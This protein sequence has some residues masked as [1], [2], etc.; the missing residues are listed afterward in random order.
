MAAFP[1]IQAVWQHV[2][3]MLGLLTTGT[4]ELAQTEYRGCPKENRMTDDRDQRIDALR[5]LAREGAQQKTLPSLDIAAQKPPRRRSPQGAADCRDLRARGGRGGGRADRA[6]A[7]FSTAPSKQQQTSVTRVFRPLCCSA[8]RATALTPFP[9][10]IPIM[11]AL[12]R[13]MNQTAGQS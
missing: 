10:R 1:L 11:L 7:V 2:H 13:S 9:A 6:S 12:S 5:G 8:I 3:S 4:T